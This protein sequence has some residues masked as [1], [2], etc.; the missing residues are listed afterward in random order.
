[1]LSIPEAF[2]LMMPGFAPL[3]RE[4]VPLLEA[5]GR[6]AAADVYAPRDL[7]GFDHSAMDG[8]AVRLAEIE[9]GRPL[10]VSAE[11]RAGGQSQPLAAGTAARI[12]TGAPLPG[13]ADT[14]VI[15]ENARA[16]GG[17]IAFAALP[18][19]GANVRTRGYDVKAGEVIVRAGGPLAPGEIAILAASG[20]RM[21]AVQRRPRVA[22]LPTGDELRALGAPLPPYAIYESN[23]YGLAAA[24]AQ[25]GC[26]AEPQ[27]IARDQLDEL[28]LRLRAALEADVLLTI[29]GV[30]VGEYDFVARA[31]RELGVAIEFHKVAIKPGKP[32]LFG[33][34][35]ERP[36]VGL[37]GNPIS[38]LVVFEVFVQPCLQRMLGHARP[39]P[40]LLSVTLAEDFGHAPGRTEFLRGQLR[41]Q[42]DLI[43]AH[44]HRR[45]DSGAMSSLLGQPALVIVPAEAARVEAGTKLPALV[46]GLPGRADCP[47]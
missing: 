29:G 43:V 39:Y 32:L 45:Q 25:L 27:P 37:P 36:I 18:A 11:I 28:R 35:G 33:R 8:Y 21:V 20:C 5:V 13:G 24:I 26:I 17:G 14:V 7:P 38:A 2:A 31:L 6:I 44:L 3:G 23:T 4:D 42:G 40:E 1:M 47:Y 15:Q 30:S 41:R 22:I 12:F 46:R 19:R 9:V 34:Y 10:P 16:S